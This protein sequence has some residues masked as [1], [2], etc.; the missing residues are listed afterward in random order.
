[1]RKMVES[2]RRS[3]VAVPLPK[4]VPPDWILAM[5]TKLQANAHKGDTGDWKTEELSFFM[6][7]LAEEVAELQKALRWHEPRNVVYDEAAD[8]ANV[9]LMLADSYD[10]HSPPD[11]QL[12]RA[13][14][15]LDKAE[16]EELSERVTA[17]FD[18]PLAPAESDVDTTCR[19]RFQSGSIVAD[20][21]A[22]TRPRFCPLG[23]MNTER[24][25]RK[26]DDELRVPLHRATCGEGPAVVDICDSGSSDV[27]SIRD[28]LRSVSREQYEDAWKEYLHGATRAGICKVANI[29]ERQL[30]LMM[31][32]GDPMAG[33]VSFVDRLKQTI[34]KSAGNRGKPNVPSPG[35]PGG[36][37]G[38]HDGIA[39]HPPHDPTRKA[40]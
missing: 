12:R 4:M 14:V 26:V 15:Q 37:P 33:I 39:D 28:E 32:V 40:F 8:V 17:C 31:N 24:Y 2:L 25:D 27:E 11:V 21:T 7:K 3:G 34:V 13:A 6:G 36:L 10:W 22:A 1:M 18:C 20:T 19:Y 5:D 9:A 23:P 16:L 38:D 30:H 29:S 35:E